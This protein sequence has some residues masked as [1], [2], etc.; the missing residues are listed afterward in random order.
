MGVNEKKLALSNAVKHFEL[1]GK[2]YYDNVHQLRKIMAEG[3]DPG[4]KHLIFD[5]KKLDMIDSSGLSVFVEL[6]KK[7]SARSGKLF[8]YQMNPGVEKVFKLTGLEQFVEIYPDFQ[9]LRQ[10]LSNKL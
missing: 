3:L 2:I 10:E 6:I 4:I 7:L 8:F 9:T 1:T 5:C